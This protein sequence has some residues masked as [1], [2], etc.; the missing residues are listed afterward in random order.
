MEVLK[1]IAV[2]LCI[3]S[4]LFFIVGL[5][6]P[7]ETVVQR[8]V[9]INA[10][11][12]VV[13]SNVN[14]LK[15]HG[16]WDPRQAEDKTMKIE[17]GSVSEGTGASY[18]WT[19][20]KGDG[21]L[22]ITESVTNRSIKADLDFKNRGTMRGRWDFTPMGQGVLV[23]EKIVHKAGACFCSRYINL[24]ADA[25]IGRRLSSG[26]RKLKEVSEKNK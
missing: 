9:I 1:R 13:F 5:S 16:K 20:E 22:T 17:Y 7:K 14:D 6:L 19:S 10:P 26:L 12:A 23:S 11:M 21:T 8:S 18:G 15:N 24:V 3:A 4:V 25:E 2:G